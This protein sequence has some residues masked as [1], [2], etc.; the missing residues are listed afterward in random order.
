[1]PDQHVATRVAEYLSTDD[2]EPDDAEQ[3]LKSLEADSGR[4]YVRSLLYLHQ[5]F[6]IAD[7]YIEEKASEVSL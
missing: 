1:M 7:C 2:D 3:L 4:S 6:I 5:S